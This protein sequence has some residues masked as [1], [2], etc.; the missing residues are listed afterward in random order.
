MAKKVRKA[1]KGGGRLFKRFGGRDYPPDAPIKAAFYLAVKHEGKRTTIA[2][3]DQAGNAI[4]NRVKAEAERDRI[5]APL[6]AG[7]E[8]RRVKAIAG[9]IQ[10][11]EQR[12]AQAV[13]D[14]EP[15]LALSDAWEAYERQLKY[16]GRKISEGSAGTFQA[17]ISELERWMREQYPEARAL[18]DVTPDHAKAFSEYLCDKGETAKTFNNK[19]GFLRTF[20]KRME[21]PAR[22]ERNP[23]AKIETHPKETQTKRA[24]TVDE[25]KRLIEAAEGE[26][27]T[28]FCLGVFTGMRLYDCATLKW[29]EVDLDRGLIV[30]LPHKT[31]ATGK[32]VRV[33]IPTYLRDHL[34]QIA[35]THRDGYIMPEIAGHYLNERKMRVSRQ[36]KATFKKAGI[37]RTRHEEGR[38]RAAFEE[39]FHALRHSYVSLMAERGAPMATVQALVGHSNPA[40]TAYYHKTTDQAALNAA[41][42]FTLT[43]GTETPPQREPMP[44]WA[45]DALEGMTANNWKSIRAELLH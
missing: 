36:I 6:K 20:F 28:L 22:I 15:R 37:E 18:S 23:F 33:G 38:A 42:V 9:V 45:V 4:T 43:D 26:Y 13:A 34:S 35:P 11:A 25:L 12:L 40:M 27:K 41:A 39:G 31:K 8:L 44:G 14:N 3:K 32:K 2:L 24:L 21:K 5:T 1:V 16:I 30:R 19:V 7:D 10:D 29:G 17:Y